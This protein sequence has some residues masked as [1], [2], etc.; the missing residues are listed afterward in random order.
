VPEPED[1]MLPKPHS[2]TLKKT[3]DLRF[4]RGSTE[5]FNFALVK[6][7]NFWALLQRK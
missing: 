5:M 4:K 2:G 3:G 6:Q 1:E 7:P